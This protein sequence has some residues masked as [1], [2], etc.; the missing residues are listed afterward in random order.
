M[1]RGHGLTLASYVR[2]RNGLP[3]GARGSMANMLRRSFGASSFAGFWRYWNPIFSYG[4]GR[5]VFAPV[6]RIAPRWLALI[7][8]FAASGLIH[9]AVTVAVRG[10]TAFLFTGFF[11]FAVLAVLAG[12]AIGM[13][14]SRHRWGVRAAANAAYIGVS[15]ALAVLTTR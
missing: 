12:E 14:L 13:N 11:L 5:F 7:A 8:T 10:S 6:S 3:L 1:K 9:D 2:Q 15:A 4:L